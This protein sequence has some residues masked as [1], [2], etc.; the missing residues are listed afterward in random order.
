MGD[1]CEYIAESL[2]AAMKWRLNKKM[3]LYLKSSI[4]L[5]DQCVMIPSGSTSIHFR[6]WHPLL[7]RHSLLA[8]A[9][10]RRKDDEYVDIGIA[11]DSPKSTG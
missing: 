10:V 3:Y 11:A 7:S 1:I 5:T 4:V 2:Y 6:L 8:V 9:S